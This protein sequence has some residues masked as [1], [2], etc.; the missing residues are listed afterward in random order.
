[1]KL[2]K[3]VLCSTVSMG[4]LN[5]MTAMCFPDEYVQKLSFEEIIDRIVW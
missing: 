2:L 3:T 1:M 4:S 5:D